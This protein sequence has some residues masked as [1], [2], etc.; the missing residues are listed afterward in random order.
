LNLRPSGYE[1]ISEGNQRLPKLPN[2]NPNILSLLTRN[3][4]PNGLYLLIPTYSNLYDFMHQNGGIMAEFPKPK[5]DTITVLFCGFYKKL[6]T[7]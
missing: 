6:T 5:S 4:T 2:T 7:F 1:P 3:D